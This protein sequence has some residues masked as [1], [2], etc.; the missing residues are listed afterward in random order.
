[1]HFATLFGGCSTTRMNS[2]LLIQGKRALAPRA[3]RIILRVSGIRLERRRVN[4]HYTWKSNRLAQTNELSFGRDNN[5]AQ[6][7]CIWM[8]LILDFDFAQNSAFAAI[9]FGFRRPAARSKHT[10]RIETWNR[11][12]RIWEKA[13]TPH[14][15][16]ICVC[17]MQSAGRQPRWP[18]TNDANSI[19]MSSHLEWNAN[20]HNHMRESQRHKNSQ[21]LHANGILGRAR[22]RMSQTHDHITTKQHKH[23]RKEANKEIF[24]RQLSFRWFAFMMHK[25]FRSLSFA[26]DAKPTIAPISI[27]ISIF[28][29]GSPSGAWIVGRRIA[30]HAIRP[31]PVNP[32]V[33]PQFG[34][35]STC[36]RCE[37]ETTGNLFR[38]SKQ[39]QKM[40][41][42]SH[43][44]ATICQNPHIS[45]IWTHRTEKAHTELDFAGISNGIENKKWKGRR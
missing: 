6:Q 30:S 36:S 43:K 4:F 5:E 7:I 2:W 32:G 42:K 3:E 29:T 26:A 35:S 10:G 21:I 39:Q 23:E 31:S 41:K 12:A 28:G 17:G 27:S 22:S 25:I 40:K 16:S 33:C 14:P 9:C 11:C 45:V 20:H 15:S 13:K 8:E 37:R 18:D 24:A 38:R 1:M 19:S 34:V 44:R